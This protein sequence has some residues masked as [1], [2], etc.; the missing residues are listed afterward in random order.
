VGPLGMTRELDPLEGRGRMLWTQSV[1]FRHQKFTLS[2]A[3]PRL[4]LQPQN[5][6]T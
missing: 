4:A 5:L 6:P 1:L 2:L 3:L